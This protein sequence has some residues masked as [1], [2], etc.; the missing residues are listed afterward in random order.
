MN[1]KN[2]KGIAWNK[3]VLVLGDIHG[4]WRQTNTLIA[5]HKPELVLQ[6]GDF[7]WWPKHHKTTRIYSGVHRRDPMTGIK[8]QAPFNQY[9]LR[10]GEAKLYWC[11]GN[12]E[13]WEDLNSKG[14]SLNPYPIEVSKNIFYMPRCATLNLPDG[15]R[16][17]FMGGAASTDKEYRRYR[18]DWYPEETIAQ[19]D[20]YNLPDVS[21][22]IVVSHT[23]P[24]YFKSELYR[25]SNDWRQ[26]D[27]YWLEKFKDPSCYALDAVYEKYRPKWWFF[28]HYHV[29][30]FGSYGK[31]R[32]FA[33]NK[34]NSTGWWTFLPEEEKC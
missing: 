29:S 25:D 24:S 12:H 18:Y 20:I 9:G 8:M 15:R 32:W 23:S 10:I 13:D 30:K 16:V 33:L 26:N 27:S 6:C 3:K 1:F 34:D 11:A 28:G 14:T 31:C 7:G 17:L 21:I 19:M 22:D 2:L 4:V 5:K